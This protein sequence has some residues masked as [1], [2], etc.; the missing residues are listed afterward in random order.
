LVLGRTLLVVF[1]GAKRPA[2]RS[3]VY[4]RHGAK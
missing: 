4:H 2:Y 3:K 1:F